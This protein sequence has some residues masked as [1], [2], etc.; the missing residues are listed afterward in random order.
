MGPTRKI[1][2]V[3]MG[4][5]F[6]PNKDLHEV[7]DLKGATQGRYVPAAKIVPELQT[8]LKDLNWMESGRKLKLGPAKATLLMNQLARD[9]KF[10]ARL[11]IMDYS[12]LVGLHSIPK[13]NKGTRTLTVM[14]PSDSVA[15]GLR[16]SQYSLV[17]AAALPKEKKLSEF[18]VDEGGFRSSHDDDSVGDELYFLGII[19]ILTPYDAKKRIEHMFKVMA[20]DGATISTV[21]PA[22]YC[23]RFLQ[24]M[25]DNIIQD[26]SGDYANKALPALPQDY[27]VEEEDDLVIVNNS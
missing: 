22:E 10:L 8:T 5:I 2:F 20:H 16:Q 6:P 1:Y 3:V 14:E 17:E 9:C 23:K 15:N 12:L 11:N 21:N 7:Y 18:Y 27:L 25:A 19:D 24:F 26:P 4:N 13:G